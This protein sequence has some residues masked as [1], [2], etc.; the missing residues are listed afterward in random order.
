MPDVYVFGAIG[1]II[2]YAGSEDEKPLNWI[3][4]DGAK[5]SQA[6]YPD[7]WRVIGLAYSGPPHTMEPTEDGMFRVPNLGG[8]AVVG[9]G[10]GDGLRERRQGE[11]GGAES[12]QPDPVS[13]PPGVSSAD[14]QPFWAST[15]NSGA[16]PASYSHTRPHSHVVTLPL[17]PTLPPFI[18]LTYLICA[19]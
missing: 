19:K 17:I 3:A 4:C 18:G 16:T 10:Q 9:A 1:S 11:L 2:A 13:G 6:A 12:H 8:R 15:A 5:L 7:L 14:G